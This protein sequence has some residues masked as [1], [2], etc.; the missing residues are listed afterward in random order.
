MPRR[1]AKEI[2]TEAAV[3]P[4]PFKHERPDPPPEMP[5]LQAVIWR[6]AVNSMRPAWFSP[7][8]HAML[9]RYC[10]GMAECARLEG[11]LARM[12]VASPEYDRVSR[13]RN[14]TATSALAYAR[15]LRITP[16]SNKYN[17][18]NA[19]DP[20]RSLYPRPWERGGGGN[21]ASDGDE[22]RKRPWEDR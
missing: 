9:T 17:T 8:T 3:V 15:A 11:E 4:V 19:R 6:A 1:S 14:A 5:E 7:E 22:P 2:A 13:R 10:N 16:Q 20:A 12:D 21:D 18:A